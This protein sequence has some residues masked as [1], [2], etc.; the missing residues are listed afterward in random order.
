[1]R[2]SVKNCDWKQNLKKFNINLTRSEMTKLNKFMSKNPNYYMVKKILGES[3]FNLFK[4]L[5]SSF[6]PVINYDEL[7]FKQI[8]TDVL[9]NTPW[10]LFRLCR[11]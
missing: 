7:M 2:T 3:K 10:V 11:L 5:L 4:S 1:M 8:L 9:N 6:Y